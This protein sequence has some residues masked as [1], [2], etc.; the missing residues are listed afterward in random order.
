MDP[1]NLAAIAAPFLAEAARPFSK[2]AW[3]KLGAKGEELFQL[4]V[5]KFKGDSYAE[6][7]LF[8]AQEKPE[9]EGRLIALKQVLSEKLESDQDFAEKV[10]KLV[11]EVTKDN[12]RILFDQ[13]GQTVHVSQTN[14]AGNVSGP[15]I[16]IYRQASEH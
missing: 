9:A 8:R 7:T 5:N 16:R 14:I 6:Q 2:A 4:V 15:T 1:S 10:K 13:R 12:T 11:D 3:N